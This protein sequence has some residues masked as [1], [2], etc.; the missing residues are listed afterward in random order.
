MW[1]VLGPPETSAARR[2]GYSVW[3]VLPG[4]GA[5]SPWEEAGVP[6]PLLAPLKLGSA[7]VFL[8]SVQSF[9]GMH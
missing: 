7:E 1:N 5:G 8:M 4:A 3:G 9:T 6:S 2:S